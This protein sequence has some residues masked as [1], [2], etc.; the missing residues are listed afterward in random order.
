[1]LLHLVSLSLSVSLL[2]LAGFCGRSKP[3]Y[4]EIILDH[5]KTYKDSSREGAFS[6]EGNV[7]WLEDSSYSC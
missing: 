5:Y 6:F 2:I 3:I 1:L 4:R 7:V